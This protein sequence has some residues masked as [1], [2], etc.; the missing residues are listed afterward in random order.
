MWSGLNRRQED[1]RHE[2]GEDVTPSG[3]ENRQ[4][5]RRQAVRRQQFRVV[6]PLGAAPKVTNLPLNVI[7]IS[8]KAVRF[9]LCGELAD[10]VSLEKGQRILMILKFHDEQ[11]VKVGGAILR[12]STDRAGQKVYVCRF[13]CELPAELVNDEQAFILKNYP[14][15]YRQIHK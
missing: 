9:M 4:Q 3:R 7:S 11:I 5:G 6:Y 15:F 12:H 1:R 14:D 8:M 10:G 2:G 13:D